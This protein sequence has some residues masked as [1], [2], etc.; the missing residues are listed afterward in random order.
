MELQNI[1]KLTGKFTI[2]TPFL[3][4]DDIILLVIVSA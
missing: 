4:I 2:S 3:A 1:L